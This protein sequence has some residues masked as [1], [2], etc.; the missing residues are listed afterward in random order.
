MKNE[1]VTIFW[2]RPVFM[3]FP[4][5]ELLFASQENDLAFLLYSLLLYKEDF[6][7]AE[8]IYFHEY[9]T[10]GEFTTFLNL[11]DAQIMF[12]HGID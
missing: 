9:V 6:G 4:S 7:I 5:Y 12:E 8:I 11:K 3:T 1:N 10:L 2:R